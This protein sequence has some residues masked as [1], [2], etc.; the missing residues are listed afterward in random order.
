MA[1]EDWA[2]GQIKPFDWTVFLDGLY[3]IL[4]AGGCETAGRRGQGGDA[5]LIETDRQNEDVGKELTHVP[6]YGS[7]G[8]LPFLKRPVW[9][10]GHRLAK[11][12][13]CFDVSRAKAGACA[14]DR[15]HVFAV[16]SGYV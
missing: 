14:G 16:L 6:E 13:Q 5:F 7:I 9:D 15:L 12:R 1:P 3:R 10:T 8:S 4:T 11:E 2:Y